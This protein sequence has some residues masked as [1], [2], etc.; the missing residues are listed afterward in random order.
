MRNMRLVSLVMTAGVA[1][2]SAGIIAMAHDYC[3]E[4][5]RL[6]VLAMLAAFLIALCIRQLGSAATRAD[7]WIIVV[8]LVVAGA[9]L[10]VD[11]RAVVRYRGLCQGPG[12]PMIDTPIQ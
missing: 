8:C 4:R 6:T 11:A 7:R 9:T 2:G 10:F 1:L 5:P 3:G 12:G